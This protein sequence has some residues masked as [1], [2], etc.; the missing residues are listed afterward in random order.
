MCGRVAWPS[1]SAPPVRSR[2][3][4]SSSGTVNSRGAFCFRLH[5]D[6]THHAACWCLSYRCLLR[7]QLAPQALELRSEVSH[8]FPRCLLCLES[9]A[10]EALKFG[11]FFSDKDVVDCCLSAD[12]L[13]GRA[14][15]PLALGQE[16]VLRTQSNNL[17]S[18]SRRN[19]ALQPAYMLKQ[20]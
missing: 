13:V 3:C 7:S 9:R 19:F 14:P 17:R 10:S 4:T 6:T 1:T 15:A 20:R 11:T 8:C 12:T 5:H 18:R 2:N 16:N